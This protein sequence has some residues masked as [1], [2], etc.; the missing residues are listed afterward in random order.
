M[1]ICFG[2]VGL[3]SVYP[4]Q[5]ST[6]EV[7]KML[8]FAASHCWQF[9]CRMKHIYLVRKKATVYLYLHNRTVRNSKLITISFLF[10]KILIGR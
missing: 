7:Y 5:F 9:C 1:F 8:N 10:K 2:T 4:T 6:P 3:A